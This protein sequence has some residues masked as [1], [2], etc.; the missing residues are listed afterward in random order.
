MLAMK[1][2][3]G[4]ALQQTCRLPAR[5]GACL[6]DERLKSVLHLTHTCCF[7]V[8][9]APLCGS[10]RQ[11]RAVRMRLRYR[12]LRSSTSCWKRC[13][14]R[15][16]ALWRLRHQGTSTL[17]SR[18]RSVAFFELTV[19]LRNRRLGGPLVQTARDAGGAAATA[20]A[21]AALWPTS[22]VDWI[23]QAAMRDCPIPYCQLRWLLCRP[24][25]WMRRRASTPPRPHMLPAP[26]SAAFHRRTLLLAP[27]MALATPG[28]SC[29]AGLGS[30]TSMQ[31]TIRCRRSRLG[32]CLRLSCPRI[33]G[34][35]HQLTKQKP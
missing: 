14:R 20:A 27:A 5:I 3:E 28:L 15:T 34:P 8:C 17:E 29:A 12:L 22:Q 32:E 26:A 10:F 25:W 9:S 11:E 31:P 7:L 19:P 21:A 6:D 16:T 33:S 13:R 1:L 18:A 2:A 24:S 23:G 30:A 35:R 4:V